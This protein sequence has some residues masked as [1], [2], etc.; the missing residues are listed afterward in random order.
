MNEYSYVKR[1]YE[2]LLSEIADIS[3]RVGAPL[4][5]LVAVTKSATDEELL[6][7]AES[8]VA[9]IGENRPQE[10]ARRGALLKEHGY[11]P[12][13]HQIGSLQ[14]NK[15][16]LIAPI[17]EL[18]H[19]VDSESQLRELSRAAKRLERDISVLIE[20]NSAEEPQKGGILPT[21]AE[22]FLETVL[23]YDGIRPIGLMT[24]GPAI[25]AEELRPYY[26][27]TKLLFDKLRSR[28]GFGEYPVLSM[29]MSDSYKIAIEEGSTL[30]RVGRKLFIK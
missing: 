24:M 4:P 23:S 16:K 30:V 7:L 12:E 13:L 19:S 21:E 18:I 8:G 27:S 5:K 14:S 3:A 22:R 25:A 26:R 6:A 11:S 15:V 1:N 29:G 17:S 10:L 2:Q 20:I 28:Y 9:A